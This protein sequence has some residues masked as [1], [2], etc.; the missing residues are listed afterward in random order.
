[1]IRSGDE[2]IIK[3]FKDIMIAKLHGNDTEIKQG[4]ISVLEEFGQFDHFYNIIPIL[5][6]DE[7][8]R[9]LIMKVIETEKG[10]DIA[11][12]QGWIDQE[13]DKWIGIE[14]SGSDFGA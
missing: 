10:F 14:R 1:M 4:V 12:N 9:N 6:N 11:R 2:I 5:E 7:K 8:A 13:M 3:E